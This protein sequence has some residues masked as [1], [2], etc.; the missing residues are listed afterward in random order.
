MG[1][2][3]K[4]MATG[5]YQGIDAGLE[6]ESEGSRVAAASKDAAADCNL[7]IMACFLV[8]FQQY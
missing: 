1:C 4:A 2:V 6:S 3:L 5:M 8:L 7:W